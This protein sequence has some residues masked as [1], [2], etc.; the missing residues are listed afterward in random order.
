MAGL[1]PAIRAFAKWKPWMPAAN[2]SMTG[3]K[4]IACAISRL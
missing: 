3:F 2:M 1:V 4:P